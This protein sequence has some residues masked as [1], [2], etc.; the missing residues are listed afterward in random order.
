MSTFT[1][2]KPSHIEALRKMTLPELAPVIE[3]FDAAL[4]EAKTSLV[5]QSDVVTIHRLQ[6]KAMALADFLDAIK[7]AHRG[8]GRIP[9]KSAF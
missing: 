5:A 2:A 6:G 3:L 9:V 1:V 7:T 8:T 4:E